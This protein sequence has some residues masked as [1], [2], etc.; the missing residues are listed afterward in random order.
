MASAAAAAPL[1]TLTTD[2]GLQDPYVGIL[3]SRIV[4]RAP[5]IPLVDLTHD[6]RRFH[7]EEAGYWLYCCYPQLPAGTVH[8]AVVDPGVGSA[9]DI[10]VLSAA[11]QLFVAPDN[12]LLGLIVQR[13]PEAL[14]WRVEARALTALGLSAES[15]TFHGRD[16]MAPLGAELAMRRVG[17]AGLGARQAP[18]AGSL[19][20]PRQLP[21]GSLEGCVAVI[22]HFG[23][24]L[25]TI[26]ARELAGRRQVR[27]APGAPTLPWV[28][29]YEEAPAGQ[30]V[31]LINS[32][33]MLELAARQVSAA[34]ALNV[35]PGQR[36]YVSEQ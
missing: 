3:K 20:P 23:N 32:A 4:Q 1:I 15:A 31:A 10:L 29:T 16:I 25:T 9:R 5:G 6:I 12:G 17:A 18:L 11:G 22:D 7:P 19:T 27:L 24:V 8:V 35:A 14:A 33:G 34:A 28:S 13:L 36:V 2:Y 30:C 26:A 21:D